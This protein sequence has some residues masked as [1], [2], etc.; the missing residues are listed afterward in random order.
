MDPEK[1][2]ENFMFAI[3]EDKNF[4]N[5]VV[6]L[7]LRLNPTSTKLGTVSGHDMKVMQGHNGPK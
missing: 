4:R 1:S 5:M 2:E 7:H 6:K 3:V